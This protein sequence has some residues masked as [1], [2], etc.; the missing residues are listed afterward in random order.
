M[1]H[2]PL[3][4]TGTASHPLG[5]FPAFG[6]AVVASSV[7]Y[8]WIYNS[9]GGSLL[10]VVLFRAATNMPLSV[11]P[12]ALVNGAVPPFLIFVGLMV[13]TAAGVAVVCG[14]VHLSRRQRRLVVA[15]R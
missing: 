7:L 2:L 9:T 8:T 15:D 3:W 12:Y 11:Y 10:I 14:P 1:W 6:I 5:L 4:L 13:V